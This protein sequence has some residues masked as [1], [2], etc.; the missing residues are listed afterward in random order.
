MKT[1]SVKIRAIIEKTYEIETDDPAIAEQ[2]A[3]E[4]F[5][6]ETEPDVPETYEQETVSVDL[7]EN[8]TETE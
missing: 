2:V 3:H 5:T 8:L 4:I 1:Y 7:T 6:T